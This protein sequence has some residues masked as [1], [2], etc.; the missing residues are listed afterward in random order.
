MTSDEALQVTCSASVTASLCVPDTTVASLDDLLLLC[1]NEVLVDV[2]GIRVREAI[3]DYLERNH[4]LARSDVSIHLEVFMRLLEKLFGKG[5]KTIE[6]SII[7]RLFD[8][9][10]WKFENEHRFDFLCYVEAVRARFVSTY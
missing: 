8:K 10:N 2:L 4:S 7:R 6:R 1:M 9:L 5:G 3:Y